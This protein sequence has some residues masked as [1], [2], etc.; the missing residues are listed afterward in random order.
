[1]SYSAESWR[2]LVSRFSEQNLRIAQAD[3]NSI[4]EYT[5]PERGADESMLGEAEQALGFRLPNEY[6]AFLSIANGWQGFYHDVSLLRVSSTYSGEDS[7]RAWELVESADDGS[8]GMLR[9]DRKAYLPIA[10]SRFDIDVFLIDI[11]E[12]LGEVRWIA[13]QEI[14]KFDSFSDF[15]IKMNEYNRET[16]NDLLRDP[17]LGSGG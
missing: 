16:L 15:M 5:G 10:V 1:M 13:G 7:M 12:R 4:W 2:D 11:A 3:I 9:I 14:E 8:G 6:R 17:W